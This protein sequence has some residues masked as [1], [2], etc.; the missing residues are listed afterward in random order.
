MV[1]LILWEYM[2]TNYFYFRW[3]KFKF[4]H[5]KSF[6]PDSTK[7]ETNRSWVEFNQS[8]IIFSSFLEN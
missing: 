5:R 4:I 7:N 2:E 8:K 1:F 3:R 6:R